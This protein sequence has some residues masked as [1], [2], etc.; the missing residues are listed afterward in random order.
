VILK[1]IYIIGE[2]VGTYRTQN[3]V[4]NLL[5]AKYKVYYN[6]CSIITVM[7]STKISSK[8]LRRILMYFERVF[9][10]P[11]VLYQIAISNIVIMPAMNSNNH[12]KQF[13]LFVAYRIFRKPILADFYISY[14]DSLV[15]DRKNVNKTS[16]KSKL[17]KFYDRNV[18]KCASKVMFLNKSERDYYLS[19]TNLSNNE[20]RLKS[21]I[22]PLC[23]DKKKIV[24]MPYYHNITKEFTICWWG[25]YIPL[26]G[27][28]QII[29]AAEI[30]KDKN[31]NFKLWLFGNSEEKSI[32]YKK[33][34]SKKNL[35]G[36]TKIINN[37][38][39]QNNKLSDFLFENCDL[40]LGN[41]GCSKKAKS[42]LVNK[43]I[44]GIAMKSP[45][46]TGES[47]AAN[48]FFDFENDIWRCKNTPKDIAEAII[49]ISN[50]SINEITRRVNVAYEIYFNNFSEQA[51]R[52]NII[53]VIK[54]VK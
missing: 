7:K 54:E 17:L 39:F 29:E 51:Y 47:I 18:I 4:K 16:F 48:E 44:D 12:Y 21:T 15:L 14:Y 42:V 24:N 30:L 34:I 25:S 26:H 13:Q 36:Y 27:L 9:L 22:V 45:V 11:Q 23:V 41:F 50:C 46:L 2:A 1:N 28:Q 3:I 53:E 49:E 33:L 43:V 8:I 10:M 19:V 32:D 52:N 20:S 37:Y 40:V 6:S 31:F 5:D 35:D 38:T